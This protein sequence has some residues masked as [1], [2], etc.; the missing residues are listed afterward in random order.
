M[1]EAKETPRTVLSRDA[2]V[3]ED[4]ATTALKVGWKP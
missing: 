4:M 3:G 2:S 1:A